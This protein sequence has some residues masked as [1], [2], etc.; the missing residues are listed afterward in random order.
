MGLFNT[1]RAQLLFY[2]D[3]Y[4]GGITSDG[5][6]Y[7]SYDYLQA[8]TVNFQTH[9]A[10]GSIIK[11]AFLLS[12]RFN[13]YVGHP[14]TKDTPIQLTYNNNL[15]EIDSSDIVTPKFI[16]RSGLDENYIVAKDVTVFTQQ[17]NNKLI[18]PSQNALL[19]IT[20]SQAYVYDGFLL[21]IMYENTAM[22]VVN[23]AIYLNNNM[24]NDNMIEVIKN[25]NPINT[26][27]DVGLSIWTDNAFSF[28]SSS[29][30][31]YTLNSSSGNFTLGTLNQFNGL[32]GG[33]GTWKKTLPGSFYYEN[34][35]L[36]GLVDD[37]PDAFIDSTDALADIK[38][39]IANSATSFSLTSIG[40]NQGDCANSRLANIL[41]YTTP[42]PARSSADSIITY[43]PICS[44][45]STQLHGTS[46]GNYTWSAANNSLN[47]YTITNPIA[48]PTVTTNYIAL[49][50]SNGCK[51]TEH[52]RVNV[53]TTPKTDSVKTTI[54]VCGSTQGTATIVATI[55]SPTSYTVNGMVQ[56][57]PTFTNLVAGTYTF[58]LSN[59]FGCTY[60]SPKSFIIKDTNLAKA[61]FYVTPASGCE[62]LII[63]CTNLS[64][65]P[66]NVTN[67]YTW[68]VN[69]DSATTPNFNYTF[70]DTGTYTLTLLA[71]ETLR[72]CSATFTQTVSVKAC[73][74]DS[75]SIVVPNI[76]SPNGDDI[77]ETWQPTVH[78]YQ[79]TV[80]NYSCVIYDRWGIKVFE[81]NNI[82]EA[83]SGRS[84]SG[85]ACSAGSYFYVLGYKATG[86]GGEVKED[87][88]KGFMELTR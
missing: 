88:L 17:S 76:F 85:T 72:K 53:Y 65:N 40:N 59:A 32:V 3:T 64:N 31:S 46:I 62:P 84:T 43:T 7:Y 29:T 75:F 8:D 57:T 47:N 44:G 2:Q 73:P 34:N 20:N 25:L 71:Y 14:P 11:K 9:V 69:G 15:L 21:V 74:P 80:N 86:S 61:H 60:T 58:A 36:F 77:N 10:L 67:S 28:P 1:N 51:H 79:Y 4:K 39:Y 82:A 42:C 50:D 49:I 30:L 26:L 22:P 41:A 52:H 38:T 63:S 78:N 19:A 13:F 70:T 16:C 87:K 37:T 35:T 66:N 27:N 45:S 33:S 83:W 5:V 54:G 68:Y 12:W 48:S 55:G 24:E 18:I 81:T 56:T 6:S 23:S